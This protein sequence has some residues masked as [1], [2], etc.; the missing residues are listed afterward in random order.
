MEFSVDL[1]R[2]DLVPLQS[3][4]EIGGVLCEFC[5]VLIEVRCVGS[6]PCIL[7]P[8]VPVVARKENKKSGVN[9]VSIQS[10]RY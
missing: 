10:L 7:T 4:A 9:K 8:N 1:L 5:S 3:W 2:E 6:G